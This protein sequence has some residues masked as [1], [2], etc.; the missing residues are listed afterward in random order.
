LVNINSANTSS[1]SWAS[2]NT[3]VSS[4]KRMC[5]SAGFIHVS[6]VSGGRVSVVVQKN[7]G[8]QKPW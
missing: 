8:V 7:T 3:N 6:R 1:P 5:T 4:S 2:P